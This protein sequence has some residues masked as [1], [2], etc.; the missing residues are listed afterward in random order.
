MKKEKTD[1]DIDDIARQLEGMRIMLLQNNRSRNR[2]YRNDNY[3]K[4][5]KMVTCWNC[6]EKGHYAD[7]CDKNRTGVSSDNRRNQQRNNQRNGSQRV[8]NRS[9]NYLGATYS[10]GEVLYDENS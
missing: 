3:E 8:N 7:K 2:N 4:R 1:K 6:G 5:Q 9:L 10:E